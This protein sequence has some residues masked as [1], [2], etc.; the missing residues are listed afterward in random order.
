[1]VYSQY[2]MYRS[3]NN[4]NRTPECFQSNCSDTLTHTGNYVQSFERF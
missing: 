1:M 3:H 2:E 4:V